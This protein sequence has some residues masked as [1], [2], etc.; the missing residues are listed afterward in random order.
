M[1]ALIFNVHINHT[2]GKLQD[3]CIFECDIYIQQTGCKLIY[4]YHL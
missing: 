2:N 4:V 1:I 3:M